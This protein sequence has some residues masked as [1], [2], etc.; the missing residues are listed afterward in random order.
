MAEAMTKEQAMTV[1]VAGERAELKDLLPALKT[2]FATVRNLEIERTA[3]VDA[4][5]RHGA[6]MT[7]AMPS[8]EVALAVHVIVEELLA[9]TKVHGPL[10]SPHEGIGVLTEEYLELMDWVRQKEAVRIPEEGYAEAKQ[11]AAV[12]I[13]FMLDCCHR[14]GGVVSAAPAIVGE[15]DG[16]ALPK[17]P[18]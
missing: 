6:R 14:T 7:V 5:P 3:L 18:A 15:Q 11:I 13:R 4:M 1:A 2:L 16:C 8:T 10:K 17:V 12:C 9:A